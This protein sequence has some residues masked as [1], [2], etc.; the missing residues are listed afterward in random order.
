MVCV[1]EEQAPTMLMPLV[2]IRSTRLRRAKV[3][4]ATRKNGF[5]RVLV[6]GDTSC[7]WLGSGGADVTPV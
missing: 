1:A 5:S 2:P 6:D 4:A 7:I 3:G